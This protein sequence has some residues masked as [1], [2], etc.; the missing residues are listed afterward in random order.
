MNLDLLRSPLAAE[1]ALFF[2]E[3]MHDRDGRWDRTERALA[4]IVAGE[5]VRGSN[6]VA[7][8]QRSYAEGVT[9]EFVEPVVLDGRP[10]LEADDAAIFFNF[11]P[12]RMRQITRALAE[13][14]FV[15][16]APGSYTLRGYARRTGGPATV[17][18]FLIWYDASDRQ[19]QQTSKAITA[20]DTYQLFSLTYPTGPA[21]SSMIV[22]FMLEP[23]GV[24]RPASMT[25][26]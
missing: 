26:P 18:A 21:A 16:P 14:D 5:G 6:P 3:L 13:P 8:L 23:N 25:W 22:R 7:E 11:R 19:L 17:T 20:S 24:P 10:R 12:D 4:A 2:Q 9:D 15:P 1:V